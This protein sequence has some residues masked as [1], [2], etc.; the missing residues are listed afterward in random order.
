MV[1][2]ALEKLENLVNHFENNLTKTEEWEIGIDEAGRGPVLGP[3]VYGCCFWPVKLRK[4][5]A[6]IGFDDSK[7]LKEE[8]RDELFAAIKEIS[9][10]YL[11][12]EVKV[13]DPEYIS[14]RMLQK[15]KCSLNKVSHDSAIQLIENTLAKGINVVHCYLDT[16]GTAD[17][18]RELLKAHFRISYPNVKFTVAEKAESKYPVVA[19]ASICAK[20][21]RDAALKDWKFREK[22]GEEASLEFG[23]GYPG[24]EKTI[25]WLK[26]HKDP[27]F[28]FPDLV[29][30][31]WKTCETMINEKMT[32]EYVD[33][34]E[35]SKQNNGG[36]LDLF[37]A[38]EKRGH[39]LSKVSMTH[40]FVL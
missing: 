2:K 17:T 12:F 28:G 36:T 6:K 9:G 33:Q 32:V 34:M 19:A 5:L 1:S 38:K 27:I 35:Q 3:M 16:V 21:S 8:E 13:L 40:E 11:G 39:F 37:V 22:L 7:N 15:E 14:N 18:Y 30:F 26:A 23:S 4:E 25:K 31:S 29:R 24:D 20:V 10:K